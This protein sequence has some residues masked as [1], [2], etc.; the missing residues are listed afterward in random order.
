VGR[1]VRPTAE[2][3]REAWL[4]VVGPELRDARVLDLFAGS[5]ALGLEAV[6]RGARHATF[7]E[8][9]HQSLQALRANITALDAEA[10]TTVYRS[11][12]MKFVGSLDTNAF[13][14]VLADPPFA[15]DYA[16]QLLAA[17]RER[18]FS[19]LLAVEHHPR[20]ALEGDVTRKWGDIAV[21]FVR[22]A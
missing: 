3:V 7:V 18:P 1:Q 6:S 5:G 14:I 13:D 2:R 8:Q 11:D 9:D 22:A 21:T 4:S 19:H 17:W 20:I 10:V 12:A 16:A 15:A